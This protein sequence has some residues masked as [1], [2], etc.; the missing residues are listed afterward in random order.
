MT[1]TPATGRLTDR[2]ADA[3]AERLPRGAAAG[4]EGLHLAPRTDL[5][6]DDEIRSIKSRAP[7]HLSTGVPVRLRGLAGFGKMMPALDVTAR[8]GRPVALVRG[9]HAVT[10]DDPL[11]REIGRFESHV[12]DRYVH[13][14]TRRETTTRAAGSGGRRRE[15][16]TATPARPRRWS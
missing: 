10:S 12:R 3:R 16:S 4:R 7:A 14:V 8:L 5:P 15:R 6:E 2:M 11:G 1:E 9:D 13:S